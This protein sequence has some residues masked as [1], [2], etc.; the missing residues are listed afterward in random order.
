MI[1]ANTLLHTIE[2]MA[3]EIGLRINSDKTEYMRLS[4]ENQINMKSL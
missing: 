3:K 4:H 2:D 1:D